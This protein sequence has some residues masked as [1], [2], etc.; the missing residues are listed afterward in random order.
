MVFFEAVHYIISRGTRFFKLSQTA[1]SI[2][3]QRG[4]I[5]VEESGFIIECSYY[6]NVVESLF[7]KLQIRDILSFR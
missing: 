7:Y 1:V 5:L 3:V 2:A 4:H 6:R